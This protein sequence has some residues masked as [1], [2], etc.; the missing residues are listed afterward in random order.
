MSMAIQRITLVLTLLLAAGDGDLA[1]GAPSVLI[2]KTCAAMYNYSGVVSKDYYVG[3]LSADPV[4]AAATDTRELAVVSANL[5][6]ANV[7]STVLVLAD[8]VHNLGECLSIYRE[9]N[10]TLAAALHDFRAGH[11]DTASNKLWDAS[12]MPNDCD[13]LLFQGSAKKNPMSKE[14]ADAYQL[15]SIAY[16][17]SMEVLHPGRST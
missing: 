1:V 15:S 17:I 4:G 3:A 2:T 7:T 16:A 5:T 12:G 8:L 14:D 10:D 11:V 13:I 9:M 6:A